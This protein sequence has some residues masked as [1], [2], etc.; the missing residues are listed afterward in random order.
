M[1][2]LVR[3]LTDLRRDGIAEV[4]LT[5]Q[6]TGDDLGYVKNVLESQMEM[7]ERLAIRTWLHPN[8]INAEASF[9]AALATRQSD[10]GQW[11]LRSKEFVSWR[12]SGHGC[13]WLYGIGWC[14][15]ICFEPIC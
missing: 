11:L 12:E 6:K 3:K 8:G 14:F 7:K 13:M 15:P 1:D 5:T 2:D 10:T 4:H 9:A